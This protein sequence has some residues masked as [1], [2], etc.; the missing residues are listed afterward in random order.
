MDID[1]GEKTSTKYE[2]VN[3]DVDDSDFFQPARVRR[4]FCS[5]NEIDRFILDNR[6]R[7]LFRVSP[8][9]WIVLLFFTKGK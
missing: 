1:K 5:C 3:C 7:L 8:I 2:S 4:A 9:L 6:Y